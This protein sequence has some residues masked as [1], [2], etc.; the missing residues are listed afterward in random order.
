MAA[1]IA[2]PPTERLRGRTETNLDPRHPLDDPPPER[3]H[4][5][6]V[7]AR[8]SNFV[9][10][11]KGLHLGRAAQV[12]R[13]QPA[14]VVAPDDHLGVPRRHAGAPAAG[15]RKERVV[16]ACACAGSLLLVGGA[17][18]MDSVRGAEHQARAGDVG[19]EVAGAEVVGPLVEVEGERSLLA[20]TEEVVS[21]REVVRNTRTF[22]SVRKS[23]FKRRLQTSRITTRRSTLPG[24]PVWTG[25][26]ATRLVKSSS[27]KGRR[28]L[29]P[30][31][32]E[33][34]TDLHVGGI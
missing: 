22:S 28:A 13:E 30:G 24:S 20:Q 32:S 7:G 25:R 12:D 34:D 6:G 17:V 16:E 29:S 19:I 11:G 14:L 3:A 4:H 21:E 9:D 8:A 10:A 33:S 2:S 31:P 5:R 15:Q 18:V 27:R 26:I 23:V 1:S